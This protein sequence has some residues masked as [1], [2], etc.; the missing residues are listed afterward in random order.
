MSYREVRNFIELMRELGFQRRISLEN[1][2]SPNFLLVAELLYWMVQKYDP[3]TQISDNIDEEKDRVNFINSI[4]QLFAVKARL[5]L[6]PR[7]LYEANGYA[8][9]EMLKIATMLSK[10]ITYSATDEESIS[11]DFNLSGKLFDLKQARQMAKDIT[12]I[13]AKLFDKMDKETDLQV[14]RTKALD[15]LDSLS[16]NLDSNKEQEYIERCIKDII[17]TQKESVSQMEKMYENLKQDEESLEQKIKRK[18][19]ELERAEKRLKSIQ[20]VRPAFMDEYEQLEKEL[21]KLYS[22]YVERYRNLD[23]LEH[24][25][26]I[27]NQKEQKKREIAEKALEEMRKKIK[28]DELSVLK[29]EKPVNESEVD[30]QM[31]K[32]LDEMANTKT[33]FHK[34]VPAAVEEKPSEEDQNQ[35]KK[36]E[37]D[38][39]QEQNEGEMDGQEDDDR[40]QQMEDDENQE[41][42]RQEDMQG[43]DDEQE[44]NNDSEAMQDEEPDNDF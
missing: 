42:Q 19:D 41:M 43:E 5:K 12:D 4:C 39:E 1:F 17:S 33:G 32:G 6:N 9:R 25:L 20:N 36:E 26:D 27:Y 22:I 2:K 35:D 10:A 3:S 7:K 15:F 13:G 14:A 44:D 29:G 38:D 23:Y 40:Q 24:E 11:S 31:M 37:Q 16:K 30:Q 8:I 34:K 28:Q 18:S 21:E